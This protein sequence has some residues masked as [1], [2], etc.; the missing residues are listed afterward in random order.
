MKVTY[1]GT[2]SLLF[3]D[4]K[5]QILFDCH[6]TRPSLPKYITGSEKTNTA[7]ADELIRKH[8]I[9]RLKAIFIH[10]FHV[11]HRAL[12]YSPVKPVHFIPPGLFPRLC[13]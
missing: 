6:I 5:D 2:T 13:L 10:I 7:L 4:G 1:L 3:D 8:H 11:F 12:R 9:D